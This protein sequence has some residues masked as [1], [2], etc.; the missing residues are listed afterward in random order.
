MHFFFFILDVFDEG[1]LCCFLNS[2]FI[3]FLR[4]NELLTGRIREK[5]LQQ[6]KLLLQINGLSVSVVVFFFNVSI[7]PK[8]IMG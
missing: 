2:N 7:D 5:F 3:L 8:F 1:H 6:N 4:F